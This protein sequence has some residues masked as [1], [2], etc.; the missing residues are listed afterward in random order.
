[1]KL[2]ALIYHDVLRDSGLDDSGF[3][4]R[5]AASYKLVESRFR[6]HLDLIGDA[7]GSSAPLRIQGRSDLAQP[8][9]GVA[10]TFDD[11]GRSGVDRIAALLEE[12]GW[13]AH[14]FITTNLID[15]PGFMGAADLRRL[16]AG[17]HVV[18]THSA[19]HPA[20]MSKLSTTGI[21]SEWH[22]SRARIADILG[23]PVVTGSVPG[24]FYS[25]EVAQMAAAAGVQVL[26]NSEPT[27]RV[28]T[29]GGVS[30]VG[31]FSITRRTSD[32]A[33]ASLASGRRGAALSQ[34]LAWSA[35]KVLKQL[36]GEAWLKLRR[37]LF[38]L[39]AG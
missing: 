17:G 39:G 10:L 22:D 26:F 3:Q 38:D 12:R 15:E 2:T 30:V 37:T 5:D 6:R 24:G 20:R 9:E 27:R 32:V 21:L 1:M 18:G 28:S 19:S 29:L 23:A 14:F 16:H 8:P 35:K 34:Q 36:G 13:R 11:G 7:I 25:V 33:L 4:G 31:R